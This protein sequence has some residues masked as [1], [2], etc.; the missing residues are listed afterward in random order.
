MPQI[1][2]VHIESAVV[3]SM[4]QLMRECILHVFFA[5]ISVLA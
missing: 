1:H 2:P 4:H 5:E 3:E